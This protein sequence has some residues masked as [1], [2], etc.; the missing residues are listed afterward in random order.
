MRVHGALANIEN[1]SF[2]T[3]CQYDRD[4]LLKFLGI[5]ICVEELVYSLFRCSRRSVRG[6]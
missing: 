6:Y 5:G 2:V 3:D 1:A 4:L